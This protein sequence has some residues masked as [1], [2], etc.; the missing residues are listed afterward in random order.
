M[1]AVAVPMASCPAIISQRRTS[2]SLA[3]FATMRSDSQPPASATIPCVVK[4]SV[5]SAV[6]SPI[7]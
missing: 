7:E 3:P 5:V 6:I 2:P 1:P 4:L